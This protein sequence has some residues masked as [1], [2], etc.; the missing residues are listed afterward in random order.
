MGWVLVI[1]KEL[2]W[3]IFRSREHI[4]IFFRAPQIKPHRPNVRQ[5][6]RMKEEKKYTKEKQIETQDGGKH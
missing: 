5:C 2:V 6:G 4:S 1:M 3:E